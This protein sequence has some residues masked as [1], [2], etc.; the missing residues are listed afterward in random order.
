MLTPGGQ[1]I[2][3]T[4]ISSAISLIARRLEALGVGGACNWAN[5]GIGA[6]IG[7][8]LS[9]WFPILPI[10]GILVGIGLSGTL[11]CM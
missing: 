5:G 2:A 1:L 7:A 6:G 11:P 3:G 9:M 4:I 10:I 8:L